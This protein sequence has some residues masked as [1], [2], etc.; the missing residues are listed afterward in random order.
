MNTTLK[1]SAGIS[2]VLL[3][4]FTIIGAYNWLRFGQWPAINLAAFFYFAGYGRDGH[5]IET[6][7]AGIDVIGNGILNTGLWYVLFWLS[8]GLGIWFVFTLRQTEH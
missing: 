3:A 5:I 1:W 6:G 7:W 4:L 8:F 2:Y